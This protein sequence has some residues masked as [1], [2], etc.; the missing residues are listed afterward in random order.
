[1]SVSHQGQRPLV[2]CSSSLGEQGP[3]PDILGKLV[4]VKDMVQVD[5]KDMRLWD[6][7]A[8]V[9]VQKLP[10]VELLVHLT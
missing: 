7:A 2:H 4:L 3:V 10:T 8:A 5:F 6:K 9:L 1:M